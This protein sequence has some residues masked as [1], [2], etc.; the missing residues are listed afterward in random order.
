MKLHGQRWRYRIGNSEVDVDNAFSW[1]DW[2][3]ER[4]KVNG[5]VVKATGQWFAFRRSFD[6]PWL[7][8]IGEGELSV[9]MRSTTVGVDCEVE[10]D[11]EAIEAEQLFE[12][13]WRGKGSWPVDA[14]WRSTESFTIFD[15][16]ASYK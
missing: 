14:D 13:T 1:F 7:T 9:R 5:E 10:L 16:L 2:A 15:K 3:Q 8:P 6:E 12:A 11:G 4:F